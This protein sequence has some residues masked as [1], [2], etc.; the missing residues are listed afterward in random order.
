MYT[1]GKFYYIHHTGAV[2][3]SAHTHKLNEFVFCV[4]GNGLVEIEGKSYPFCT[5]SIYITK[6]G[7]PHLES[8]YSESEIIYFYFECKDTELIDGVFRDKNGTVLPILRR[9]QNEVR[10]ERYESERMKSA[11]LEQL[12]I[13]TKR[14]EVDPHIEKGFLYVL[15]YIDENFRYD[16]DLSLL[17]KKSGYSYDR[18]RHIFKEQTGLSPLEYITRKRI[19]MAKMLMENDR[20]ASMTY[21]AYECGFASSSHFTNAFRSVVETTPSEYKKRIER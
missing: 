10:G 7:V 19:D 21:I 6:A 15:E 12:F 20:T 18:F 3:G 9:L 5:G 14:T 11:L 1:L 17:A 16:L 2:N 4:K 13:E 8:D